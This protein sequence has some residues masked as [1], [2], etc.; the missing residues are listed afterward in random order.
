MGTYDCWIEIEEEFDWLKNETQ[1][2]D[3]VI[4]EMCDCYGV[5]TATDGKE[6][7]SLRAH[8][9]ELEGALEDVGLGHITHKIHWGTLEELD[10]IM[11]MMFEENPNPCKPKGRKR[12][13]AL[14]KKH[15]A[16]WA[17]LTDDTE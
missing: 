1:V 11:D 4:G 2:K 12:I 17:P 5:T 8:T 10:S 9:G 7:L 3:S 13:R 15:T 16:Y 6:Y 14:L